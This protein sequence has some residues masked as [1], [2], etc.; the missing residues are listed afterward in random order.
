MDEYSVS[1][2]DG[3]VTV[4][5]LV[6]EGSLGT[7]VTLELSTIIGSALCEFIRIWCLK[8]TS[9]LIAYSTFVCRNI[10]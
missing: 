7:G 1:E 4:G 2:T 8:F 3:V 10:Q 6:L 5:V 9:L